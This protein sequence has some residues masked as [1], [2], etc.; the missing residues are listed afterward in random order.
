MFYTYHQEN[1]LLLAGFTRIGN[2]SSGTAQPLSTYCPLTAS[3]RLRPCV[4]PMGEYFHI[5]AVIAESVL[6]KTHKALTARNTSV[7]ISM[8]PY[9]SAFPANE[10][11][12]VS[13]IVIDY[14]EAH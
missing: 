8:D 9:L 10:G 5:M 14:H 13:K 4:F 1:T 2:T 7:K 12:P 11:N 3:G 6:N